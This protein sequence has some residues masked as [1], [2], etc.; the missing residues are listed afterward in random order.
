VTISPSARAES[1]YVSTT[2]N[3]TARMAVHERFSTN[4][5]DWYSWLGS[6]LPLRGRVLEVGAGTGMLWTRVPHDHVELTLTDFSPVMCERLAMIPGARVRRCD[7]AALPFPDASFDT[8][9]AN[10][11][12]YHTDDPA[13]VLRELARVSRPGGRLVVA[14]NGRRHMAE[15]KELC[16]AMDGSRHSDVTEV[17]GPALIGAVFEDVRVEDF[18]GDL[19][20]TEVE[21]V[22]GYVCS[23]VDEPLTVA[24]VSAIREVVAARIAAQGVFRVRKH[25]LLVTAT[26]GLP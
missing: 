8:V 16:T 11:M 19:A 18:P 24:E 25:V 6:R 5:Q 3:L 17:T 15:L 9:I 1:Q 2:G 20:I 23:M 12:L 26:R 10:H 21:P 14:T 4:P 7:A 13:A 22:I